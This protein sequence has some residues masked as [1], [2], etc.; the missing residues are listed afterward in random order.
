MA[1]GVHLNSIR[2][3]TYGW[4][5]FWRLGW[6]NNM[7]IATSN[8]DKD[9]LVFRHFI[10]TPNQERHDNSIA[11]KW[12]KLYSQLKTTMWDDEHDMD[13][14]QHSTGLYSKLKQAPYIT[15]EK[16]QRENNC[17]IYYN[18]TI[19]TTRTNLLWYNDIDRSLNA[20]VIGTNQYFKKGVFV[21]FTNKSTWVNRQ[22]LR[23]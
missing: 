16:N 22:W 19:Y 6:E 2:T 5:N 14:I 20:F 8:K 3:N 15:S 10:Y 23:T 7:D 13:Y 11:N 9:T 12:C 1:S 21:M 18:N 4:R 17:T